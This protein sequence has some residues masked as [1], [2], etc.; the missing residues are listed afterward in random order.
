MNRITRVGGLT[1][2]GVAEL[3][4]VSELEAQ[5]TLDALLKKGYLQ[6]QERDEGWVYQTRFG[7]KRGQELPPGLWSCLDKRTKDK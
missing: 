4:G 2:S 3:M 7:R 6:R 5:K 1:V